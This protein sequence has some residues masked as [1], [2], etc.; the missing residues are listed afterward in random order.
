M[1]GKFDLQSECSCSVYCD[2]FKI[3]GGQDRCRPEMTGVVN[4]VYSLSHYNRS[5][6]SDD[7]S[8]HGCATPIQT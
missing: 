4:G 2:T 8:E 3:K 5:M 1:D 7:E 6:I